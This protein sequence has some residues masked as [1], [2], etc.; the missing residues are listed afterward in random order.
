MGQRSLSAMSQ[1]RLQK[2][3]RPGPRCVC[4]SSSVGLSLLTLPYLKGMLLNMEV[5][6]LVFRSP[7]MTPASSE[8]VREGAR[9]GSELR[10]FP[11]C[12]TF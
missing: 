8:Q 6:R 11:S 1:M 2:V 5:T 3:T 12:N 10:K 7:C 4:D 9:V